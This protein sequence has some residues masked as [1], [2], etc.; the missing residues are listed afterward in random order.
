MSFDQ[1][2]IIDAT[3]GSIAR[4][5]NHSCS[6]NCRM[7]KWIVS[8]QPRMAL[9]AGDRPIMT[10]EE[11]TYDYNFDPFSAK[12]VQKCLC[13]S[14]NCRGVL[15]PKPKEVKPPKPAKEDKKSAKKAS[16]K[17]TSK[18]STKISTKIS[19]KLSTKG[20][21]KSLV[22]KPIKTS[23]KTATKRKLKD[24]FEFDGDDE[25]DAK[26]VKKRKIKAATGIKRTLSSA[27]LKVAKG[28][29]GAAKGA[30]KG[31]TTI[32]RSVASIS[33][34]AKKKK[35]GLVSSK[36]AKTKPIKTT[37]TTKTTTTT[38]RRATTAGI[39]K[40]TL[41][42]KKTTTTTTTAATATKTQTQ[43]K[44]KIVIPSRSPSLTIVAAGVASASASASTPARK[45]KT[46]TT[47]TS[48]PASSAK[49]GLP[50][51][52]I[53][54]SAKTSSRKCT[55]SRKAIESFES[56]LLVVGSPVSASASAKTKAAAGA[57][58]G[59][60]EGMTKTMPKIK[61]VS[62]AK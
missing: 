6:P 56:G 18:T 38:V 31:V 52:T 58:G 37:K 15:G 8:G 1:N 46:T 30:A 39:T 48:T 23:T 34:A 42:K 55:P 16:S 29:K 36:A 4:F 59:G 41:G 53:S 60:V 9:F 62:A 13:G 17:T 12:N 10:G 5:V 2:M 14:P 45:K 19:A 22:K 35:A 7:I 24:A 11:L 57:K 44:T 51:L 25:E 54:G 3:T 40:K 47:S 26:T 43:T 21:A 50:K 32:K 28:A 61:L 27:S 33:V 49:K 20:S